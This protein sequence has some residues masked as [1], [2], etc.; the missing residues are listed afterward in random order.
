MNHL[1]GILS[2]LSVSTHRA[3]S[4]LSDQIQTQ[5][6]SINELNTI[7]DAYHAFDGKHSISITSGSTTV[8]VLMSTLRK[9]I[10]SNPDMRLSYLL[11][12]VCT[13]TI[14]LGDHHVIAVD[15]ES[16]CRL[17]PIP[18][19]FVDSFSLPEHFEIQDVLYAL[20]TILSPLTADIFVREMYLT[21][22]FEI[23]ISPL[24]I[25][26]MEIFDFLDKEELFL[27]PAEQICT[28]LLDKPSLS[29]RQIVSLLHFL[30][31]LDRF[32][33]VLERSVINQ[34]QRR[35]ESWFSPVM[36]RPVDCINQI[37]MQRLPFPKLRITLSL[38][39]RCGTDMLLVQNIDRNT[40]HEGLQCAALD[41]DYGLML[42]PYTLLG[43]PEI[44]KECLRKGRISILLSQE[45]ARNAIWNH[46]L[47]LDHCLAIA[48]AFERSFIYEPSSETIC[49]LA[50]LARKKKC[51]LLEARVG[52]IID[53]KAHRA[54]ERDDA[55][56][57][58]S[59]L[60]LLHKMQSIGMPS[61]ILMQLQAAVQSDLTLVIQANAFTS[62]TFDA[63]RMAYRGYSVR[64]HNRKAITNLAN[65]VGI[66][67]LDLFIFEKTDLA[68]LKYF[69]T[70]T[71][72]YLHG[73]TKPMN[74][75]TWVAMLKKMKALEILWLENIADITYKH[76][77]RLLEL[78]RL[79]QIEIQRCGSASSAASVVPHSF[80]ADW[81]FVIEEDLDKVTLTRR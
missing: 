26:C 66:Q 80:P 14:S 51:T 62:S 29:R 69:R 11:Q 77:K 16:L 32:D 50:S 47:D 81:S 12:N 61:S 71:Q 6:E 27:A 34:I 23:T 18:D 73:A 25:A 24:C 36:G 9:I 10:Q 7:S 13:Y 28:D 58:L 2:R 60:T 31:L 3:Y 76:V 52:E 49:E 55:A 45:H 57:L 54:L 43:K 64:T 20:D 33:L 48:N 38:D 1:C 75:L 72:L 78:P 74:E 22:S 44:P 5:Q 70:V 17:S 63:S 79:R 4:P 67:V 53:A 39:R 68:V 59:L 41:T 15:L 30:Q 8:Y 40:P 56:M 37:A 42:V 65:K 46:K 19:P 35:I 21:S